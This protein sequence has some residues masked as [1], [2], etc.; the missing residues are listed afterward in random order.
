MLRFFS[1][2]GTFQ[3]VSLSGVTDVFVGC[4]LQS[5]L[6]EYCTKR[7]IR[8][9]DL[10]LSQLF[11]LFSFHLGQKKWEWVVFSQQLQLKQNLNLNLNYAGGHSINAIVW[12]A[13]FATKETVLALDFFFSRQNN[14]M[15]SCE[16][17]T[18]LLFSMGIKRFL[19]PV[20]KKH[21]CLSGK[22]AEGEEVW[23]RHWAFPW[24]S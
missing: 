2:K 12:V 20:Y 16:Y 24:Q 22:I 13:G 21:I 10:L 15:I 3:L 7:F 4:T 17:Q 18:I 11:Y 19:F 8:D 14:D 5:R 9:E 6:H 1:I 23:E